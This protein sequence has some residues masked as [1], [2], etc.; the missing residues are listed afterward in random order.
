MIGWDAFQQEEGPRLRAAG[1]RVGIGLVMYVEGTG[2]GPYEGARVQV[3]PTGKVTVVTGVGTQGQGHYTSFAQIAAEQLGVPLDDVLVSTGDT[4]QFNWGT[5]T[6]ASRGATVA[7]SAV[8]AAA[9]MVRDKARQLAADDWKRRRRTSSWWTASPRCAACRARADRPRRTGEAGQ[10]V[11]RRGAARHRAGPGG[12]RLLRPADGRDGLRRA[13]PDPGSG[14]G[15][16]QRQGPQAT[17]SST[18]A[19]G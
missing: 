6:F 15:D 3:E 17:W 14:P 11:A 18:T 12:D 19:G 5:G 2:I 13:R 10:P 9:V 4:G 8:H 1:K 16:V 7:G